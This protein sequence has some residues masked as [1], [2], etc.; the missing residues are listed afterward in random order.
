MTGDDMRLIRQALQRAGGRPFSQGDLAQL[1][2]LANPYAKNGGGERVRQMEDG[3][4]P[5]TGPV[6]VA[7]GYLRQGLPGF[8]SD[9]PEWVRPNTPDGF[10]ARLW[11]PRCTFQ[12]A[13][14]C[15]PLNVKW[16]DEPMEFDGE[17]IDAAWAYFAESDS[18]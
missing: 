8:R 7:L 14:D 6:D 13:S 1:L 2:G 9:V 10:G 16:I 12:L 5:I 4:R 3:S 11:W 18:R 17:I 15:E